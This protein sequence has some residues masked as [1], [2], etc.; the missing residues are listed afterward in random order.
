MM[1]H[2]QRRR[3]HRLKLPLPV[4]AFVAGYKLADAINREPHHG[5]ARAWE[6]HACR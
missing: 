2:A 3:I 1:A 5:I 6:A 4:Q